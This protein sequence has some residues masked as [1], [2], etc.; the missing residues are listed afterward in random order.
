MV[1]LGEGFLK[2]DQ[3]LGCHKAVS[4]GQTCHIEAIE[5]VRKPNT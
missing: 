4:H 1:G 2:W 5:I 3:V